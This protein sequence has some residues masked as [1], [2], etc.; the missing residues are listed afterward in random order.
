MCGM[1]ASQFVGHEPP[2]RLALLLDKSAEKAGRSF[3]IPP[4]L[5]EDIQDLTILIH[6]SI[7]ITQFSVDT[8]EDLI[9]EPLIATG[10]GSFP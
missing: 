3:R 7:Q 4:C 8:H 6:S 1:V 2:G 5:H 9:D 10:A